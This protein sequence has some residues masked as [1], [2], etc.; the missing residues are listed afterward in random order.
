[1]F[2]TQTLAQHHILYHSAG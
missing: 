1:M 2:P